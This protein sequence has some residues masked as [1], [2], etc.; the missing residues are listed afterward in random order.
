[1]ND[2]IKKKMQTVS[3]WIAMRRSNSSMTLP[4]RDSTICYRKTQI[5]LKVELETPHKLHQEIKMKSSAGQ[6]IS[7]NNNNNSENL[8]WESLLASCQISIRVLMNSRN[9]R[10]PDE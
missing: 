4:S 1:M 3:C 5:Q 6:A 8:Q 7:N 2:Q 9:E 10:N